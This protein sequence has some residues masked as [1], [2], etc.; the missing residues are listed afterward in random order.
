MGQ[1]LGAAR[2]VAVGDV[3]HPTRGRGPTL[4]FGIEDGRLEGGCGVIDVDPVEDLPGFDDPTGP[5]R[6]HT[7]EGAAARAVDTRESKYVGATLEPS[8]LG[9]DSAQGPWAVGAAG[10]G[11]VDPGSPVVAVDPRGRQ[12]ACPAQAGERVDLSAAALEH[13]VAVGVGHDRVQE[14]GGPFEGPLEFGRPGGAPVLIAAEADQGPA[15]AV[16]PVGPVGPLAGLGQRRSASLGIAGGPGDGEAAGGEARGEASGRVAETKTKQAG[17]GRSSARGAGS[18]LMV[19]ERSGDG[20]RRGG[21]A[22]P[23]CLRRAAGSRRPRGADL[24]RA[25]APRRSAGAGSP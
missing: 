2:R 11:L 21:A 3:E 22:A 17:H 12:V 14:M 23:A 5:T 20:G 15:G 18:W 13:E 19:G 25:R 4:E 6:A 16:G 7:L 9:A 1:D 24:D 10:P 8:V